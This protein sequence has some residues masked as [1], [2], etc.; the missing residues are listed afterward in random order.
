MVEVEVVEAILYVGWWRGS[1]TIVV[2]VADIVMVERNMNRE[3]EREREGAGL[4]PKK[5]QLKREAGVKFT[6]HFSLRLFLLCRRPAS[7]RMKKKTLVTN[8][9]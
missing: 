5:K 9:I 8:I 1:T 3:K 7:Q 6:M 2:V 4:A